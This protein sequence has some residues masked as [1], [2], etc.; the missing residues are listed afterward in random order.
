LKN[1]ILKWFYERT[2]IRCFSLFHSQFLRQNCRYEKR[3]ELVEDVTVKTFVISSFTSS[4]S[5]TNTLN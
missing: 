1:K 2:I 5:C 4:P 3:A